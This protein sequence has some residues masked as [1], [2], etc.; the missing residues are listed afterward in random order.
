MGQSMR[1]NLR[2]AL[3]AGEC[4]LYNQ[5]GAFYVGHPMWSNLGGAISTH[6]RNRNLSPAV[7]GLGVTKEA[8]AAYSYD[9]D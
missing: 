9:E 4:R 6:Y 8:A 7:V 5:C 2:G 1:C 3:L